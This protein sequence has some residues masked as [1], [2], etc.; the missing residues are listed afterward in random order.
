MVTVTSGRHAA[1]VNPV[2]RSGNLAGSR[3]ELTC[4]ADRSCTNGTS[5][6]HPSQGAPVM[7][8][9][10]TPRT[11]P[12]LLPWPSAGDQAGRLVGG[13]GLEA[14]RGIAARDQGAG[15]SRPEAPGTA[16]ALRDALGGTGACSHPA[17]RGRI[18]CGVTRRLPWRDGIRA[19]MPA[20][21]SRPCCPCRGRACTWATSSRSSQ[22]SSTK[23]AA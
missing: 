22:G 4:D 12:Q 10:I 7:A 19:G 2:Q 9:T 17:R 18:H 1:R 16:C 13:R 23:T 14:N 6:A 15:Q 11:P 3:Y 5:L 21:V 20:M 8:R